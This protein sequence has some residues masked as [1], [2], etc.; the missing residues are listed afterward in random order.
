[1]GI[2]HTSHVNELAT[3]LG[4]LASMIEPDNEEQQIFIVTR[5]LGNEKMQETQM[6]FDEYIRSRKLVPL[7]HVTR[8]K[9]ERV[10]PGV[11]IISLDD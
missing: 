7:R 8:D 11:K 5:L 1:M 3:H 2:V 9:V 10:F 6:M 4:L